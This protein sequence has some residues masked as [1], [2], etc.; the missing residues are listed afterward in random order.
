[1]KW[2]ETI[3]FS[4]YEHVCVHACAKNTESSCRFI[5]Q[6]QQQQ[7]R[8]T[9]QFIQSQCKHSR[10][11]HTERES[12]YSLMSLSWTHCILCRVHNALEG[13][14]CITMHVTFFLLTHYIIASVCRMSSDASHY[15]GTLI[16]PVAFDF[17]AFV[18]I[19]YALVYINLLHQWYACMYEFTIQKA[20]AC[21][22]WNMNMSIRTFECCCGNM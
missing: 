21:E 8:Q 13:N 5:Q 6:Q 16:S 11:Y 9:R 7:R 22:W 18:L 14:L 1:M 15:A 3:T 19:C 2:I 12:D 17:V 20:H 4:L 10:A